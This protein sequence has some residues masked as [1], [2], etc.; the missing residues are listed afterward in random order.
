[1]MVDH[2]GDQDFVCCLGFDRPRDSFGATVGILRPFAWCRCRLIRL[3][4][5]GLTALRGTAEKIFQ[6]A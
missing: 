2:L 4:R 1:M 3:S 5:F 6:V